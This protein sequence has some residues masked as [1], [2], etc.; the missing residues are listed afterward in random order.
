MLIESCNDTPQEFAE[1]ISRALE[2]RAYIEQR[3]IAKRH[4]TMNISSR[5]QFLLEDLKAAE[6]AYTKAYNRFRDYVRTSESL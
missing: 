4:G 3:R 2:V 1:R 5:F 6:L